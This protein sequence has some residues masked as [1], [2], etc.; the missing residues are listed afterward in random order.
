VAPNGAV[1]KLHAHAVG[2]Q[3][4]TCVASVATTADGG[5]DQDAGATSYAWALKAP[6][7][8]LYD[9]GGTQVGTHGAGPSWT[10]R[11]GSTAVGAKVVELTAPAAEA[12]P[13]L[14]LRV[15][16]TSGAGL[17]SDATY[18]QRVNTAG[19]RAPATG[20][21]ATTVG[22]EARSGY[23]ADYY[24]FSG[25]GAATWLLQPPTPNDVAVPTDVRLARHDR[26]TG[27]QI[28]ACLASGAG[29]TTAF[30]WVLRSANV[31][32]VD[33]SYAPV[34]RL[35]AGP[36]WTAGDGSAV[37]APEIAHAAAP[38]TGA[39]PWTLHKELSTTGAGAFSRIA[40][41]QEINTSGGVAP[42]TGCGASNV[43]TLA[44]VDYAADYYYYVPINEP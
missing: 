3:I 40:F 18:V 4:Y 20:C 33:P 41:I 26:G 17:L 30:R 21:D 28:Y 10:W 24:F 6:D 31:L 19:G 16:S 25:G 23:A 34:A 43:D 22:T 14:L 11:D 5:A 7:A 2:A 36:T 32:L 8:K 13:W 15:K 9:A 39:L 38:R 12:I 27:A 37:V 44:R 1:V 35:D 42:A 29:G